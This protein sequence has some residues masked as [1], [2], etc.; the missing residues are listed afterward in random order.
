MELWYSLLSILP[1]DWAQ[2]GQMYF[3]KHALL[4]GDGIRV[5]DALAVVGI[6]DGRAAV[7]VVQKI[8][9]HLHDARLSRIT[10]SAKEPRVAK[11]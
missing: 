11:S 9:A 5:E 8:A 7:A 3:M 4:A 1:F 6:Q 10:L 2:P